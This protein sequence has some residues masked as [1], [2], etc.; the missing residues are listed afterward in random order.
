MFISKIW[1]YHSIEEGDL[2]VRCNRKS[3]L[4]IIQGTPTVSLS[5]PCMIKT[6]MAL[7]PC[8]RPPE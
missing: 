2:E 3:T 7:I 8:G 5:D 4:E 1:E 6:S